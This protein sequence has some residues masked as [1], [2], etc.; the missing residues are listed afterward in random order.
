MWLAAALSGAESGD[1][2]HSRLQ[3]VCRGYLMFSVGGDFELET[4]LLHL[5]AI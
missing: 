4:Q 3:V 1:R 5:A 2:G